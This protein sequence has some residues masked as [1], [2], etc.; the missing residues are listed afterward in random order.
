MHELSL[1]QGLV[2]YALEELRKLP[3]ASRLT[4][5]RVVVGEL[6][7]IV[8]ESLTFA[9]DVLTKDTPAAGSV[10]EIIHKP[11]TVRCR[12]C[13]WE[14]AIT[15]ALFRCAACDS[16]DVE[17]TAGKELYLDSLEVEQPDE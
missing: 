14:G 10:L 4:R 2:D 17:L 11:I 12:Q 3:P 13:A 6:R 5:V 15:G 8:P 16:T 7:R 1:C 9:Y